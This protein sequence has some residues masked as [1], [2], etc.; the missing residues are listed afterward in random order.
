MSS[1]WAVNKDQQSNSLHLVIFVCK[2][3]ETSPPSG[4]TWFPHSLAKWGSPWAVLQ[5]GAFSS[6]VHD[7]HPAWTD[8]S[9]S[10]SYCIVIALA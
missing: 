2:A 7:A 6:W 3:S 5:T 9:S 10:T 4:V 8:I 1:C